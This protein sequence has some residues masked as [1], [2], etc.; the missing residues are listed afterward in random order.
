[1]ITFTKNQKNFEWKETLQILKIKHMLIVRMYQYS[2]QRNSEYF[3]WKYKTEIDKNLNL[4]SQ[5]YLKT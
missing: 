1:M 2:S 5:T 4:S 3:L